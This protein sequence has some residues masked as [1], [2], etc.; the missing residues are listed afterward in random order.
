[1]RPE[2]AIREHGRQ[3]GFPANRISEVKTMIDPTTSE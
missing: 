2:N 3:R 1:L